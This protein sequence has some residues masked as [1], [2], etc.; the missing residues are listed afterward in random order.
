M[1]FRGRFQRN[2]PIQTPFKAV[3]QRKSARRVGQILGLKVLGFEALTSE[4]NS[5]GIC[6]S[7]DPSNVIL[8]PLWRPQ[9]PF[10]A[11]RCRFDA[12][13]CRFETVLTHLSDGPCRPQ[14]FKAV[15]EEA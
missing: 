14:A 15:T 6:R 7:Q 1:P 5:K 10:G 8:T 11:V 3:S 12:V 2:R 13:R 9:K 4:M